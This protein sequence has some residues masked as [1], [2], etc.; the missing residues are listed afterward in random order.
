MENKTEF[1]PR[2]AKIVRRVTSTKKVYGPDGNVVSEEQ[3]IT[4]EYQYENKPSEEVESRQAVP[5]YNR[6]PPPT[7]APAVSIL[8]RS[9]DEVE[10]KINTLAETMSITSISSDEERPSKRTRVGSVSDVR[11]A[12]GETSFPHRSTPAKA[13]ASRFPFQSFTLVGSAVDAGTKSPGRST[14]NPI[15]ISS[16]PESEKR[17][18][19]SGMYR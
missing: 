11:E 15:E 12:I 10:S 17:Q 19:K 18:T 16:S 13:T 5:R 14:D 4:E 3:N 6:T 2:G 7:Q 1:N 8:G 9:E